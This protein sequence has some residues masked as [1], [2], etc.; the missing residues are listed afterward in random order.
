MHGTDIHSWAHIPYDVKLAQG[1]AHKNCMKKMSSHGMAVPMSTPASKALKCPG[2]KTRQVPHQGQ[3]HEVWCSCNSCTHTDCISAYCC[4]AVLPYCRIAGV[5]PGEMLQR[6]I[7]SPTVLS[8]RIAVL[9][10]CRIAVLPYC[11]GSAGRDA[12]TTNTIT[13]CT[14]SAY[15][16]TAVLP[17]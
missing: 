14:I 3:P 7:Q 16:R 10:Y 9:P 6:P 11:R 17:G 8:Q 5:V 4:T 12:P 1:W 15:C 13:C 2:S